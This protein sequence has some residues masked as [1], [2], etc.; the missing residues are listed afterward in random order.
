MGSVT[1]FYKSINFVCTFF[2]L[3]IFLQKKVAEM[4]CMRWVRS[5]GYLKGKRRS[6]KGEIFK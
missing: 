1:L 3:V 5:G 2:E 6:Y 4:M